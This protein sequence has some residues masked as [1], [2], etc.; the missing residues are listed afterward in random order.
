MTGLLY[1][2]LAFLLGIIAGALIER[3]EAKK[4]KMRKDGIKKQKKVTI[5]KQGRLEERS[6]KHSG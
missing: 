4:E 2:I 1:Y 6:T 3:H 5:Q